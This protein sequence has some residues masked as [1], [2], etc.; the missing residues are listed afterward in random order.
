MR[1]YDAHIRVY[2][3]EIEYRYTVAD[4]RCKYE[5]KIYRWKYLTE[6]NRKF[7]QEKL[8]SVLKTLTSEHGIYPSLTFGPLWLTKLHA[9]DNGQRPF[10]TLEVL[11][12]VV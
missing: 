12:E 8:I 1:A 7:Q 11:L 3:T 9:E 5:Y 4:N 2:R 6:S 10:V